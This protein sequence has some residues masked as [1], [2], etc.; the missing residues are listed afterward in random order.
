MLQQISSKKISPTELINFEKI[1]LNVNREFVYHQ[2]VFGLIHNCQIN[3]CQ[4]IKGI[5]DNLSHQITRL[6]EA[7]DAE[8][9]EIKSEMLQ[10]SSIIERNL[11]ILR[12][13]A[14][15]VNQNPLSFINEGFFRTIQSFKG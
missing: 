14:T 4:Q 11:H 13:W 9:G 12:K 3:F 7:T 15:K 5:I 1:A 10:I 6:D 2:H 8:I